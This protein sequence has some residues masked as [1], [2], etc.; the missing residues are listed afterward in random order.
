MSLVVM[1]LMI[2]ALDGLIMCSLSL[3]LCKFPVVPKIVKILVD[4]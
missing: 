4:I 2:N 3:S 1:S